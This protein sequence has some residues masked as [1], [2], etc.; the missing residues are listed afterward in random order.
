MNRI[1]TSLV[2]AAIAGS[3]WIG[4]PAFAIDCSRASTEVEKLICGDKDLK[5]ADAALGATYF[6]L[7]KSIKDKEVHDPLFSAKDA[8]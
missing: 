8:G 1:T 5:S 7:L 2:A 3:A 4:G 6:K